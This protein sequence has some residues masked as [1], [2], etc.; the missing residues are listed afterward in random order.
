MVLGGGEKY[1]DN[2][3]QYKLCKNN[4]FLYCVLTVYQVYPKLF[5]HILF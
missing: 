3:I 2:T 1:T 5:T 4:S